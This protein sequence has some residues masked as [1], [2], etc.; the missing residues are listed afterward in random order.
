MV[1]KSILTG[2]LNGKHRR[3]TSTPTWIAPLLTVLTSMLALLALAVLVQHALDLGVRRLHDLRYGI[4]RRYHLTAV[5]GNGDSAT[6][7]SHVIALN[8]DRQVS[9][10]VLPAGQSE[11]VQVLPGPYLFGA[12]G[13]YEVPKVQVQ[14]INADGLGDV[15]LVIRGEMVVYVNDGTEFRLITEEE[16]RGLGEGAGAVGE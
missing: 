9:I 14:D 1:T 3:Q 8:L 11:H 10:L 13:E 6:H 2:R 4:P 16:R 12:D 7:P 5:L 15:V